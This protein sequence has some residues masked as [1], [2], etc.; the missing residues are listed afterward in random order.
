M[1][2]VI[3]ICEGQ[4]EKLFCNDILS[5]YFIS[6]NIQIQPPLIKKSMGG[7]VKWSELKRQIEIHLKSDN[8][9]YVTTFIDYYG[10]YKKYKFP[11]W[12]E[13]EPEPDKIKRMEILES[14][15]SDD[16]TESLRHRFIPNI[17]LHEFEGLL[18]NDINIFH[19]QI[20]QNELIGIDELQQTFEQYDNPE[21]INNNRETSPSH[22]LE[23]IILG[24][25]KV[26]YGS[27]L[28]EAIGL[29]KMR[30]KSPRFNQWLNSI[31][32]LE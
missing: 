31:E 21:M 13:A 16:I 17:Q 19:Q 28:A 32:H 24:Y 20:P 10:L 25:D 1:I 4:T 26:I 8:T 9:A 23:R 27:L 2:R 22:R 18:F 5:P 30:A 6:K 12:E 14:G 11:R 15:M 29:E 3:I 7:I